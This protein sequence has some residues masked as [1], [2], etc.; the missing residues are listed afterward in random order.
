MSSHSVAVGSDESAVVGPKIEANQTGPLSS[1][2]ASAAESARDRFVAHR[3]QSDERNKWL[4]IERV[5]SDPGQAKPFT[6]DQIIEQTLVRL[7]R[8]TRGN[9][10]RAASLLGIS[11]STLYRMLERYDIGHVGRD[12]INPRKT[13]CV[14]HAASFRLRR[15]TNPWSRKRT[16]P[17][18]HRNRSP[19]FRGGCLPPGGKGDDFRSTIG[20]DTPSFALQ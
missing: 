20:R 1:T 17:P 6:L 18:K 4:T 2:S 5:A 11:R 13:C 16:H 12:A 15:G 3:N 7:L 10:R 8:E 14:V 19:P 9:R